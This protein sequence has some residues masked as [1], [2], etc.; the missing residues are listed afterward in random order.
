[1]RRLSGRSVQV[2]RAKELV[3]LGAAAQAAGLLTG[4]DPAAV[5]RR[6][7]TAAGARCWRPWSGTRR[8]WPGWRRVLSDA[9]PLLNRG[10]TAD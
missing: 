4:E 5:A 2:P 8:R 10:T 6:W 9:A 7:D 1:M 3:A